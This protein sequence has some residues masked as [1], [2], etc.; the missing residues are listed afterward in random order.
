MPPLAALATAIHA[1]VGVRLTWRPMRPGV[2]RAAL[3][4]QAPER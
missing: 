4:E 2:V 3:M 1:A